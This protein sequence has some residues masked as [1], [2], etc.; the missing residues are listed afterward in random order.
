MTLNDLYSRGGSWNW[1]GKEK[2]WFNKT[3]ALKTYQKI[4]DKLTAKN[5]DWEQKITGLKQQYH[6]QQ[7]LSE[8]VTKTLQSTDAADKA[9]IKEKTAEIKRLNRISARDRQNYER[10]VVNHLTQL[11]LHTNMSFPLYI[12][13]F[14]FFLNPNAVYTFISRRRTYG[15][16]RA[17]DAN[18]SFRTTD[19]ERRSYP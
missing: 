4:Y 18:D 2:V 10:K 15:V 9:T 12:C 8:S 11:H 6:D 14:P 19:E 16:L 3:S 7:I 13:L 5:K 17:C 1:F